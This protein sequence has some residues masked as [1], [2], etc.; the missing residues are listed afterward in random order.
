MDAYKKVKK[1]NVK[2]NGKRRKK[3][4]MEPGEKG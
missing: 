4:E 1:E 2:D 3:Y